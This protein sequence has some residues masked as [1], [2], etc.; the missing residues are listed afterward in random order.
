MR[1][2]CELGLWRIGG[3]DNGA[4]DAILPYNIPQEF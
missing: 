3:V 4:Q 1:L 2:Q